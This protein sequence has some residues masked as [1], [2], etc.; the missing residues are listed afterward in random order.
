M[1][2]EIKKEAPTAFKVTIDNITIDVAPGT[3]VLNAARMIGGDVTPPAM[4]YYSKLEGSGGKC[5]TCLVEVAAKDIS[6]ILQ[7]NFDIIKIDIEGGEWKVFKKIMDLDL[8]IKADHWF[9]EFHEIEKN[10]K[11]FEEILNCFK[12]NGF[13]REERKEVVYFYKN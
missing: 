12:Q 8:V 11:Q 4:C 7:Q 5:R 6:E 1:P 2:E 10:K 13:K 9:V 3:T